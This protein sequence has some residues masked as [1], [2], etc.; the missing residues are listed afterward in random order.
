MATIH[1]ATLTPT[2]L[3]LLEGWLPT[4]RWYPDDKPPDLDRLGA[5][6]FDDP[7]GEVGVEILVVRSGDDG[8]PVH[9][10][11]TYRGA[12]LPGNG[13]YFLIGTL[14]HS[15]LGTRWVYDA[16][17]DPVYLTCLA[18]AIRTGGREADEFVETDEGPQ[19]RD[20]PMSVRGSGMA[21][22]APPIGRLVRVQDG[23]P[24]VAVTEAE[25][26]EVRR[27][28]TAEPADGPLALTGTWPGQPAP[29]ILA[30]LDLMRE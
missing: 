1:Q 16:V 13:E 17:G 24:A 5:C 21:A 23:D 8:P 11:L 7:D 26:V 28:L 12:P 2:K 18:T 6:R 22:G 14:E 3:E 27:V 30:V 15:V 19:R 25:R 10:P 29:L 20:V 9:V 4:R